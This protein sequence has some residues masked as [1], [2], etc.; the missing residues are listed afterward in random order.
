MK[1]AV[2]CIALALLL[3]SGC[4]RVPREPL[5][6]DP[7]FAQLNIRQITLLP[8]E[9]ADQALDRQ[10]QSRVAEEIPWHAERALQGKGYEIRHAQEITADPTMVIRIDQF[11]DAGLADRHQMPLELYA[12]ATLWM[13]GGILWQ[14]EGVGRGEGSLADTTPRQMEWYFAPRSLVESLFTTLPPAR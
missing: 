1:T 10:L 4:A 8:V 6:L 13:N 11:L 14:G 5:L 9:F 2:L 7:Q 3:V 12:T